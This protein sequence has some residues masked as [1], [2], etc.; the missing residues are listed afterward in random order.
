MHYRLHKKMS[1]EDDFHLPES[2]S[3][4]QGVSVDPHS[5]VFGHHGLR[6]DGKE[7]EMMPD[8]ANGYYHKNTTFLSSFQSP[9]KDLQQWNN[10][11]VTT[12]NAQVMPPPPEKFTNGDLPELDEAGYASLILKTAKQPS[13]EKEPVYERIKGERPISQEYYISWIVVQI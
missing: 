4:V 5:A 1:Y 11:E 6:L 3:L 12:F 9:Q 7:T 13:V 10:N 2:G 8:V